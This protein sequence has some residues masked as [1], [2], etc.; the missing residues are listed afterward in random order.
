[1]SCKDSG[2]YPNSPSRLHG[3][4][5]LGLDV[6]E[7]RRRNNAE[8]NE[9]DIGLRVAERTQ[10][11]V[12]FLT[13]SVPQSQ[14]NGLVVDH[15]ARAVVVEDS[16]DVLAGEGVGGVG[17]KQTCLADGTV[18]GDDAFQRLRSWSGHV[19]WYVK[20]EVGGG[21]RSSSLVV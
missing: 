6:V 12:I 4:S 7:T 5:Y 10:A 15:D 9:E 1:M 20:S 14:A 17:D 19:V 2:I 13:R 21:D 3:S 18:T 16:G 8:A 11:V